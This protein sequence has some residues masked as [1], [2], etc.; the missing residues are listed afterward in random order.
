MTDEGIKRINELAK[1]S[2][3]PQGL[4]PKEEEERAKLRKEFIDDFRRN[5]VGALENVDIVEK[6]GS[7]THVKD[8]PARKRKAE[9]ESH[10]KL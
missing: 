8:I 4:T 1:K 3:S 10:D 6:D 7:I 5:L 2:K 9:E